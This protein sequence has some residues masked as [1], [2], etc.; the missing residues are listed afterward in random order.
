MNQ[1]FISQP[2]LKRII[3]KTLAITVPSMFFMIISMF[4][5]MYQIDKSSFS[6][7][8]DEEVRSLV[9]TANT[10]DGFDYTNTDL[11]Y[12]RMKEALISYA[13][14]C[15]SYHTY[16][17]VSNY[18][19]I[20][21]VS[22]KEAFRAFVISNQE[23][24]GLYYYCENKQVLEWLREEW[25]PMITTG[26]EAKTNIELYVDDAYL[27]HNGLFIPGLFHKGGTIY[28]SNPNLE[29]STIT[30]TVEVQNDF[31]S[32]ADHK[33]SPKHIVSY[34]P[35]GEF[36]H[37]CLDDNIRGTQSNNAV[38]RYVNEKCQLINNKKSI[39][40]V[41]ISYRIKLDHGSDSLVLYARMNVFHLF[42][43]RY[44]TVFLVL[45]FL[46]LLCS[47]VT[48]ILRYQTSKNRYENELFRTTLISRLSHDLRTPLS[49]MMG[50]SENLLAN[51]ATEKKEHYARS[52]LHNAK[53]MNEIIQNVMVL[54][55][56]EQGAFTLHKEPINLVELSQNTWDKYKS[57]AAEKELTICYQGECTMNADPF[58]VCQ[59]IENLISNAVIHSA[60]KGQILIICSPNCYQISN[61]YDTSL[62]L[63]PEELW[64]PFVK[65]NPARGNRTGSGIGLTIVKNICSLH[66][67]KAKIIYER[68]LFKVSI[69]LK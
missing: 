27:Y 14:R 1:G 26:N 51:I 5:L 9:K 16:A 67:F 17:V 52:I 46:T 13:E 3:I 68:F 11:F 55:K 44:L 4:Y 66:G 12:S 57:L 31:S 19:N 32:L 65:E 69:T 21:V 53:Y 41:A 45:L 28:K 24:N 60:S 38:F 6:H 54:S 42:F 58:L 37:I 22:S 29:Y 25:I 20:V 2:N 36:Y 15:N 47:I 62:T 63:D 10:Y 61:T 39:G 33:A 30:E 34:N 56:T 48:I 8:I 40:D 18:D 64:K 49:A 23:N 59:M 50:Y 7:M 35:N 43:A